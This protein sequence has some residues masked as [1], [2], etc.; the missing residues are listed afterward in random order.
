MPIKLMN[1]NNTF[2]Y[3]TL[4]RE[5]HNILIILFA[6]LYIISMKNKKHYKLEIKNPINLI[7]L[8][9]KTWSSIKTQ[10]SA[11]SNA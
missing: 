10:K 9:F 6:I 8:Q 2:S 3:N 11:Y 1:M 5:E 7:Y 4:V